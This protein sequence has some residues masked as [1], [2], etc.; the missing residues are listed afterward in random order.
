[1]QIVQRASMPALVLENVSKA[2]GAQHAHASALAFDDAVGSHGGAV[3]DLLYGSR[4]DSHTGQA[5]EDAREA[6]LVPREH[7]LNPHLTAL[8][9]QDQV[10]ECAA[11]VNSQPQRLSL[12]FRYGR[13]RSPPP[14][15]K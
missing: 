10:G 4:V 11:N 8:R 14:G 6:V 13:A 5:F 7:L 2:A 1:M 3:G 9:H 12:L 15:Y